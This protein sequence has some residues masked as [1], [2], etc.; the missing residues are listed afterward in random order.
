MEVTV[1]AAASQ[2]QSHAP[3]CCSHAAGK[4][5]GASAKNPACVERVLSAVEN[6]VGKSSWCQK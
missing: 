1:E 3:V 5:K 6:Q 2:D 4:V